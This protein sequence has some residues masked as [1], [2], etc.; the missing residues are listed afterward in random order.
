MNVLI[1]HTFLF[2]SETL[3]LYAVNKVRVEKRIV[4]LL[5]CTVRR[6]VRKRLIDDLICYSSHLSPVCCISD[7]SFLK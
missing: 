6:K 7:L 1:F 2:R 3:S 5:S 4:S